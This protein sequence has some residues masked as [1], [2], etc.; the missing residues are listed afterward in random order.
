M[1]TKVFTLAAIAVSAVAL[2]L[3]T[4]ARAA[5]EAMEARLTVRAVPNYPQKLSVTVGARVVTTSSEEARQLSAADTSSSSAC[6][7]TTRSATT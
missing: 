3:P 7:A 6:G 5:I 1:R 4:A 2:A